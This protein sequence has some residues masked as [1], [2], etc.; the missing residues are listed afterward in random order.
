MSGDAG[1]YRFWTDVSIRFSDM[2]A[3]GH[4]NNV[5][6][7]AYCEAGRVEFIQSPGLS[8]QRSH[9]WAIVRL[10]I[11]F[12]REAA[13]PG[14]I[15]IGTRLLRLGTSSM[16]LGQ[17]LFKDGACLATAEGTVVRFDLDARRAVPI[18]DGLRAHY[19]KMSTEGKS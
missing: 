11:E 16:T 9:G 12:R 4:L 8:A 1:D 19:E 15:R 10:Q 2:D 18:E 6:Y 13:F 3:L 7:A 17:G 5:A 14:V